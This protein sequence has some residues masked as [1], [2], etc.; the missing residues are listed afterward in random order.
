[1]RNP[2]L[3]QEVTLALKKFM[4]I[5]SSP[6]EWCG[7]DLYLFRDEA[8][9]FYVG[10]SHLAFNRV[11]SHILGGFKGRSTVGRFLLTNW[12]ISLNFSIELMSSQLPRFAALGHDPNAAERFL[13]EKFAPCF[14]EMLNRMPT[15]LPGHYAPPSAKPRCSRSLGK[16]IREAERAI[17][18][19]ERRAWLRQL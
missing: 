12:P 18:A 4:L 10:Q 15:P 1:M 11:W 19:E 6:P 9:V 3:A 2:D 14:N 13:I 7:L 8:V 5:E 17:Q 16:L